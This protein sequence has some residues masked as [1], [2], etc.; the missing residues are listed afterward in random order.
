MPELNA[1][2]ERTDKKGG[3]L[4]RMPYVTAPDEHGFH[5]GER[6]HWDF[7]PTKN[8]FTVPPA[9][10]QEAIATGFFRAVEA[11]PHTDQAAPAPKA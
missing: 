7:D 3:P 10:A 1:E 6:E 4:I 5:G 8:T 11:K 9:I 2:I